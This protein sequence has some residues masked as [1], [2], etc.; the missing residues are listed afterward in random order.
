[1]M[2]EDLLAQVLRLPRQERARVAEELLSSLEEPEEQ[3]A[4]AWAVELERRSD[5]IAAG[6]VQ[7]VHWETAR[8]EVVKELERR[9]AGRASS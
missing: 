4:I 1:M 7:T 8:A 2:T 9:R 6:K 3:V 5:E